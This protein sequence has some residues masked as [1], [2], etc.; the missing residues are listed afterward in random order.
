M[1]IGIINISYSFNLIQIVQFFIDLLK[2][3]MSYIK[4]DIEMNKAE[5]MCS[6]IQLI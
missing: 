2:N 1:R 5:Y 3:L 4:L 6:L